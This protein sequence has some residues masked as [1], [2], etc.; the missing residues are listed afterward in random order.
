VASGTENSHARAAQRGR[1]E[2]PP[3]RHAEPAGQSRERHD[4][5]IAEH[6]QGRRHHYQ[7]HVLRHMQGERGFRRSIERRD[8]RSEQRREADRVSERAPHRYA[9]SGAG[10]RPQADDP[11]HVQEIEREQRHQ[12]NGVGI[13]GPGQMHMVVAGQRPGGMGLRGRRDQQ[14]GKNAQQGPHRAAQ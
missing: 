5:E 3:E 6:D 12:R 8:Q 4:P 11:D 7:Q 10:P 1:G 9:A 2:Y 13:P 14:E